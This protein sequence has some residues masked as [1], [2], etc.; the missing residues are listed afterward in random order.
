[1]KPDHLASDGEGDL[2]SV[3]PLARRRHD[4]WI[5]D[6]SPADSANGIS[7]DPTLDGELLVASKVLELASSASVVH[8]MGTGGIQPGGR[9]IKDAY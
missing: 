3:S 9:W 5:V 2:G 6:G 8:I 1:M 7:H 4:R